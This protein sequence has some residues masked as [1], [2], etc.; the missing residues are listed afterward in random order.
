MEALALKLNVPILTSSGA[1]IFGGHVWR[2]SGAVHLV[3]LMVE[4]WIIQILFRWASKTVLRYVAEAPLKGLA[5]KYSKSA[6]SLQQQH[7]QDD[8]MGL[9]EGIQKKIRDL[10]SCCGVA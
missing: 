8:L 4:V 3:I 7:S 9:I 1:R 5:K 6:T 2:V 10:D